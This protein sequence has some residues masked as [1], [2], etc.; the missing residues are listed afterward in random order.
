MKHKKVTCGYVIKE[1]VPD[2]KSKKERR[3]ALMFRKQKGLC[4]YCGKAM[5]MTNPDLRNQPR[6]VATIE[7]LIDR[8][9]RPHGKHAVSDTVAACWKCNNQ[10]N[11]ERQKEIPIEER[12][13]KSGSYPEG[14]DRGE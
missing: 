2:K 10:K 12:R 5:V 13:R 8:Y 3:L 4:Y 7:H 14:D 11:A 1:T 6:S 9:E